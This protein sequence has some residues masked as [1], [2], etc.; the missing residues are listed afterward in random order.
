MGKRVSAANNNRPF[1]SGKGRIAVRFRSVTITLFIIA[2]V[3]IAAVMAF[4]FSVVI[5]KLSAEYAKR[6]AATSAEALSAHINMDIGLMS[7]A[8]RSSAVIEWMLDEDDEYKK[9]KAYEEIIGVIGELY[10]FNL[11]IGLE[12]SG[13]EYRVD[14][15][16]TDEQFSH[17]AILNSEDP[18]YN[19]FYDCISSEHDY[20]IS[21]GIDDTIERKRVWLDYKVTYDGV[22][23]GVICTGLEFSH[24]AWEL[25]SQ[26]NSEDTR[27]LVIDEKGV[28]H[29]DSVLM[30]NTEFLYNDYELNLRDEFSDKQLL[31]DIQLFIDSIDGYF[32]SMDSSR[33]FKLNGESYRNMTITPIKNTS[34][35]VVILSGAVSRYNISLF[36]PV[37]VAVL[38][39][40]LA[41]TFAVIAINSRLM[42]TPIAKLSRS[43]PQ[44]GRSLEAQIYGMDRDDEIGELSRT[45]RDLFTKANVDAL[46]GIYNRRYIENNLMLTMEFLSRSAGK[47]S[48]L[49]LD[50]DFFKRYNDTYGHDQGDMCLKAVAGALSGGVSRSNDFVARYGGEEFLAVLPNTDE[51]GARAIAEKLLDNVRMLDIPHAGNDAA[52]CVT[53]SIGATTGS[54]EFTQT[55]EEYIKSADEALYM[56][57]Q[58][59]RNK[60]TFLALGAAKD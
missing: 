2:F 37:S 19:W 3:I 6:Y 34:W 11:Y 14:G 29:I 21:V 1:L 39:L 48:V 41:F 12:S 10:S 30:D 4:A 32:D 26:F 53:I 50:I 47:L 7:K 16:Y 9:A 15:R 35:S 33:A 22:P 49:M 20:L 40:L 8:A 23:I 60:Y 54:V 18:N 17:V 52:P 46:T 42:F 36:I 45:I 57:K 38:V 24:V 31:A 25:F 58:S 13:H 56:S 43:L 59:G 51:S 27:G 5:G 44:L 28:I 55:Q